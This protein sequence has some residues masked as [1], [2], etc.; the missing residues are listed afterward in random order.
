MQGFD[1]LM[2][3]VSIANMTYEHGSFVGYTVFFEFKHY[4]PKKKK[5]STRCFAFMEADEIQPAQEM[6][7]E[8]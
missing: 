1:R 6:C 4:K 5:L 3:P 7:L 2:T 8:L